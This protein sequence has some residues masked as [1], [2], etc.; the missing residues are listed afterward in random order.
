MDK[1]YFKGSF[2][3]T[4][5][6]LPPLGQKITRVEG[7]D[8]DLNL[9]SLDY[10]PNRKK[11]LCFVPSLD[12]PICSLSAKKF[13]E[14]LKDKNAMLIYLSMDLPF[15]LKRIQAEE[16]C[17]KQITTLSLFQFRKEAEK[18]TV[19]IKDGVLKDLCARAVIILN[20]HNQ[21]IYTQLVEEITHEPDYEKALSFV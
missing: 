5:G 3:L 15:A 10:F 1:I 21:V 20:E 14:A 12:T 7:M 6:K 8:K 19:I 9:K 16:K 2:I 4:S 13:T 17:L 18:Y 11:I